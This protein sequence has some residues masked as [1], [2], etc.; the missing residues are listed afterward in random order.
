MA[1][2]VTMKQVD[3]ALRGVRALDGKERS[4]VRD[5]LAQLRSGGLSKGEI[6][7]AVSHLKF[8]TGDT[9][10]TSEANKIKKTLLKLF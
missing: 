3:Q 8:N 9:I 5:M 1:K 10:G 6:K 4:Y 2:T 7:R